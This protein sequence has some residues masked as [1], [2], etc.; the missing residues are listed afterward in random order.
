MN[1]TGVGDGDR[2]GERRARVRRPDVPGCCSASPL[3]RG[4]LEPRA[5]PEASVWS[6]GVGVRSRWVWGTELVGGQWMGQHRGHSLMFPV[7]PS[8]DSLLVL[9]LFSLSVITYPACFIVHKIR[10]EIY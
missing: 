1:H 6:L 8:L 10:F 2:A 7:C 9:K 5:E 3:R 4:R